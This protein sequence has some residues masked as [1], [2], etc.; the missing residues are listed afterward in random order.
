MDLLQYQ[1]EAQRTKSDKFY[2]GRVTRDYLASAIRLA[3]DAGKRIDAIKKSLFYGKNNTSYPVN[4]EPPVLVNCT[5]LPFHLINDSRQR[6]IDVLHAALGKFTEACE[7]LELLSTTFETNTPFDLQKFI[8]EI[9]D[10]FWYDAIALEAIGTD[11]QN[12]A[13]L[14]NY[15]LRQRFPE[16]FTEE[17]AIHR[18]EAAEEAVPNESAAD[19]LQRLGTDADL[20]A[21]EFLGRYFNR[22]NEVDVDVLRAWFANAIERGK[23]SERWK[24]QEQIANLVKVQSSPGNGDVDHYMRGMANGLIVA[25]SV[26]T[27]TEPEFLPPE[28]VK[29]QE[30]PERVDDEVLRTY[31]REFIG[32]L[33]GDIRELNNV[34]VPILA[35]SFERFLKK[36]QQDDASV[37]PAQEV[38]AT[39]CYEGQKPEQADAF[40]EDPRHPLNA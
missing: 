5:A 35:D 18:N 9:G 39:P 16:K 24:I 20:W 12:C 21:N 7:V 13:G 6:G 1:T 4:C 25:Q 34:Q 29:T 23:D 38:T 8:F 37:K 28:F 27:N 17:Q 36:R 2:G 31:V 30:L 32:W 22:A 40:S 10:G 14:N 15:K 19:M 11:F 33:S 26:V 3:L